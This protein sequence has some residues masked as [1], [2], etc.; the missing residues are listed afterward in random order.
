MKYYITL[1]D[2]KMQVEGRRVRFK[3]Y[4]E[5]NLFYYKTRWHNFFI[6]ELESGSSLGLGDTLKAAKEQALLNIKSRGLEFVKKGINTNIKI[7]GRANEVISCL[8]RYNR[9]QS[10]G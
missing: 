2:G 10:F 1:Y 8:S 7:Y 9:N 6:C 4:P 5:L 3:E